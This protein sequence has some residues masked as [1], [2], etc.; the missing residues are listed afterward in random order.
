MS[1][2]TFTASEVRT[3]FSK[4]W[5]KSRTKPVFINKRGSEEERVL[6]T[7]EEYKH[8]EALEDS[9]WANMAQ[10]SIENGRLVSGKE[11]DDFVK[12]KLAEDA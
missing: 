12:M 2:L 1:T 6:I 8:F 7:A 5:E 4:M 3:N 11:L 10:E 9:Y